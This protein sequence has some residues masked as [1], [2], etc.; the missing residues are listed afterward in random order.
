MCMCIF[1]SGRI[2]GSFLSRAREARLGAPSPPPCDL[3]L[4]SGPPTSGR[5]YSAPELPLALHPSKFPIH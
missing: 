5:N 2:V 1:C 4:R 3:D